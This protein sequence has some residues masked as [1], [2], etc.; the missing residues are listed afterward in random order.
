[1]IR[2]PPRS[3]LFPYTTL[4]RSG[5]KSGEWVA[6]VPEESLRRETVAGLV[7]L[8]AGFFGVVIG[9]ILVLTTTLL[10]DFSLFGILEIVWLTIGLLSII[11]G[12]IIILAAFKLNSNPQEHK[13][14]GII[15]LVESGKNYYCSA[16]YAQ[17]S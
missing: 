13:K 10:P 16:N 17:K 14:W 15:I 9:A 2:R 1:M 4:F 6:N 11:C 5:H 12:T 3:T 8:I 7:S